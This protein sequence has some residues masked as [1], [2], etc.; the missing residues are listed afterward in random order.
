MF[1]PNVFQT[2]LWSRKIFFHLWLR[3]RLRRRAAAPAL[4][5]FFKIGTLKI[6]FF[7]LSRRTFLHKLII[8]VCFT[9]IGLKL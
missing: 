7:N 3:L 8:D 9:L 5:N 1:R 6:S 2:V 4:N